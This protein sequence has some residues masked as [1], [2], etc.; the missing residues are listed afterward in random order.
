MFNNQLFKDKE[1]DTTQRLVS[2]KSGKELRGDDSV[3]VFAITGV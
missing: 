3:I 2:D 1:G